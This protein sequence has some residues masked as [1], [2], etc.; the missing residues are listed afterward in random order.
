MKSRMMG[1]VGHVAQM[2]EKRNAY[3]LLVE[4]PEGKRPLGRPRRRCVDIRID[5]GEVDGVM[6]T[7]LVWLRKGT[8]GE[9]M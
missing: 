7:G 5:L 2:G 9:L 4:K 1:L 8:G 6:W 3:R